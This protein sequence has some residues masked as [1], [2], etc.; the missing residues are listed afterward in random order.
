MALLALSLIM[1]THWLR[2]ER[3]GYRAS[4]H[5][6][7]NTPGQQ[8]L[9][10][11]HP[12]TPHHPGGRRRRG[13]S[14]GGPYLGTPPQQGGLHLLDGLEE[15]H[16]TSAAEL[17]QQRHQSQA[18]VQPP[19]TGGS[20][21]HPGHYKAHFKANVTPPPPPPEGPDIQ[22]HAG[23]AADGPGSDGDG[24]DEGGAGESSGK[25]PGLIQKAR[26]L[27]SPSHTKNRRSSP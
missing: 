2:V 17:A 24:D 11:R 23:R 8:E 26:L 9:S 18:A 7:A 15:Q 6:P 5:A 22:G 25:A 1:E 21:A 10:L 16:A 19:H 27:A 14:G 13:R 4:L 12:P 3:R 20:T